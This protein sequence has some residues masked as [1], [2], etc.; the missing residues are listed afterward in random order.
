MK[1]SFLK[2]LSFDLVR[3]NI[4]LKNN[5]VNWLKLIFLLRKRSVRVVFLLRCSLLRVP[6]ISFLA[7]LFLRRRYGI[8]ISK[9][10][11]IGVG[12][13]FPHPRDIII[14]P[15]SRLG[16]NV[17]IAQGVTIGGNQKKCRLENNT[18]VF[19]P[20][21]GDDIWIGPNSV[22]GGPVCIKKSVLIGANT[23]VTKDIPENS[24]VYGQ[25]K[26]SKKKVLVDSFQHTYKEID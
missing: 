20:V 10:C 19:E 14:G 13:F 1:N 15:G 22:I 23:V 11:E 9:E 3:Q 26:I 16:N 18:K 8:E 6:I 2:V 17:S 5:S 25:N 21:I 12:V 7:S 4:K 24:L